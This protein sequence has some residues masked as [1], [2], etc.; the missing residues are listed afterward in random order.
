ME[1]QTLKAEFNTLR[2]LLIILGSVLA[3][4]LM[5]QGI[6]HLR[7]S[8]PYIRQ[9]LALEGNVD[10]GHAIFQMNCIGCH[11]PNGAGHVGPSLHHVS[12]HRT[13]IGLIRQVTSGRTPPMPKF[14]ASPEEMADLLS[15][16]NTL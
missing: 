1:N 7:R 6:Y 3:T 16:L 15:Y 12:D 9:V 11:G 5:I 10:R 13:Q 4:L 2:I 8:D 14:Q